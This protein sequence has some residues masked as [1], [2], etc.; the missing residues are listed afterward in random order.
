MATLEKLAE[1]HGGL[2]QAVTL[3]RDSG[4]R[5]CALGADSD[6]LHAIGLTV[7]VVPQEASTKGLVMQLVANGEAAGARVFCPVPH[8][9][10]GLT[11]PDVVPKFMQALADAGAIGQRVPAYATTMG[12]QPEAC[13]AE[14]QM[15]SS[16]QIDAIAFS[17]TA[18]AQGLVHVMG[19][20]E[21]LTSHITR[22]NVLLAAHGPYTARGVCSVL[23]GLPVKCVSRNFSSFHGLVRAL[24]DHFAAS[25]TT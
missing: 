20:L 5:L 9:T 8:V 21:A 14:T 7:H 1:L 4:L 16:G 24:E 19:G 18:E 13:L 6:T 25:S 10:G 15:L 12:T 22:N 2:E 23:G 11:E 3:L 17:S